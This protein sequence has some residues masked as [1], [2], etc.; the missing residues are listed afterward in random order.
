ML[1]SV[2]ASYI[3]F[4]VWKTIFEIALIGHLIARIDKFTL[5]LSSIVLILPLIHYLIGISVDAQ[6]VLVAVLKF[7][8]IHSC[9]LLQS[10]SAVK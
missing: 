2:F 6:P 4:P 5:T 3:S 10:T 9:G 1:L 7:T 8:I